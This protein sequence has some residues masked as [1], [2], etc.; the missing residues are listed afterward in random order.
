MS[1]IPKPRSGGTCPISTDGFPYGGQTSC[2]CGAGGGSGGGVNPLSGPQDDSCSGS[3]GSDGG[4]SGCG[5]SCYMPSGNSGE[6]MLDPDIRLK[7]KKFN[8]DIRFYYSTVRTDNGAYGRGRTASVNTRIVSTTATDIQLIQGDFLPFAYTKAGTALG[9]TTYTAAANSG[10]TATISYDGTSF[11][12]VRPDGM[13]AQYQ[14]QVGGSNVHNLTK[15]SDPSGVAHSYVY[16]SGAEAGLLKTIEVP[17][18]RKVTFSY[19]SG[20]SASLLNSVQDWSGRLWTFQYDANNSMTTEM[21]PLGC[22][23]KYI[24]GT[25]GMGVPILN[26]IEDARGFRT[27]YS[28]VSLNQAQAVAAGSSRFTF[29]YNSNTNVTSSTLQAPSGGV[30][31]FNYDANGQYSSVIT[32]DGVIATYTYSPPPFSQTFG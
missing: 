27:T 17:G 30:A 4:D 10:A 7:A 1:F 19:V 5:L 3:C 6:L 29:S 12:V 21:S 25:T 26:A 22:T 28:Y 20:A 9:I 16:G 31:T 18:G 15:I 11:T 13:Q 32:P 8:L 14:V 23:T 2:S 24:Y